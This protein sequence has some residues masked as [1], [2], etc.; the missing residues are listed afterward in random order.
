MK[1]YG[2][3]EI[4]H[5]YLSNAQGSCILNSLLKSCLYQRETN[6]QKRQFSISLLKVISGKGGVND[7]GGS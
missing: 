5:A 2:K 3:G 6:K 4:R 1:S 7:G